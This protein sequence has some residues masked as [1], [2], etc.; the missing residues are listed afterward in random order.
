MLVITAKFP[1]G[2]TQNFGN[3]E[4]LH[5]YMTEEGYKEARVKAQ[6]IFEPVADIKMTLDDVRRWTKMKD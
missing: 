5:R 3:P 4:D 2:D 1:D 6:Y